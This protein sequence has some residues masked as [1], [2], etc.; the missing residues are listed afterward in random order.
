MLPVNENGERT[1][2]VAT[3]LRGVVG[4]VCNPLIAPAWARISPIRNEAETVRNPYFTGATA[5][6]SERFELPT[7]GF[8]V[9]YGMN[10]INGLGAPCCTGVVLT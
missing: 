2:R 8:E 10:D 1:G 6:R 5:G 4:G 9:F 3:V 7:L